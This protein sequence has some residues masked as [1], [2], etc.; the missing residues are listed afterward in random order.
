[1]SSRYGK[2]VRAKAVRLVTDHVGDYGSERAA[3]CAVSAG[4]G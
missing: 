3:I 4:S 1:M 2:E